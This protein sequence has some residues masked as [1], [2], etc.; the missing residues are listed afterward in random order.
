MLLSLPIRNGPVN[1]RLVLAAAA[2]AEVASMSAH[3]LVAPV[4]QYRPAATYQSGRLPAFVCIAPL[5][6]NRR[7]LMSGDKVG[8]LTLH[9]TVRVNG[10]LHWECR[11]ECGTWTTVRDWKLAYSTTRSCG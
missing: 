5:G 6:Y 9:S 10:R 7:M 4:H 2:G 8:R 3:R 1:G 11:C